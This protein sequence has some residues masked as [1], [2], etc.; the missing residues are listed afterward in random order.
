M[1][2]QISWEI[3]EVSGIF[4][5][6]GVQVVRTVRSLSDS[7]LSLLLLE[8]LHTEVLVL[9]S[10]ILDFWDSTMSLGGFEIVLRSL[11]SDYGS[12]SLWLGHHSN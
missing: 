10:E 7:L 1:Q 5:V 12:S 3:N 11:R 9:G 6:K 8:R 2:T 4:V